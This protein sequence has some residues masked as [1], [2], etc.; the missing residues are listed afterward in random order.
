MKGFY[1]IYILWLRKSKKCFFYYIKL[2]GYDLKIEIS[3][4]VRRERMKREM[5]F[6]FFY[7]RILFFL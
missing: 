3:F 1:G 6:C 7:F 4:L 2:G 5:I